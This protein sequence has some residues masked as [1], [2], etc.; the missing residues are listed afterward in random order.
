M[1]LT[2]PD[3]ILNSEKSFRQTCAKYRGVS[4]LLCYILACFFF[5][6]HH[7]AVR[8]LRWPP[9]MPAPPMSGF[10]AGQP[11]FWVQMSGF[12][13]QKD[14]ASTPKIAQFVRVLTP[15]SPTTFR[16]PVSLH[17]I[18]A[19]RWLLRVYFH[20]ADTGLSGV[21]FCALLVGLGHFSRSWSL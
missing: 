1:C 13:G 16:G 8:I 15:A 7:V 3:M 11:L 10:R 20:E 14:P 21:H 6:G 5:P 17:Q 4:W 12:S 19:L 2:P 18:R 9:T